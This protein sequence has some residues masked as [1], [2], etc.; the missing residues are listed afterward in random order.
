MAAGDTLTFII[1][2]AST[3]GNLP[4]VQVT[5]TE[6]ADGT[7]RFVL[8][9]LLSAGAYVGDL[10]GFFMDL[11]DGQEGAL[12][13]LS[14]TNQV[15]NPDGAGTGTAT[16]TNTAVVGNDTVV[17]A[18]GNSNNMNGLT[19]GGG[20]DFGIE[21]GSEGIG[22]NGNDVRS[23]AFTLDATANLTLA[24]IANA[25]FGV[26]IMSVGQDINGDGT[27]DTA[28]NGSAKISET[29]FTNVIVVND[30][31]A[32]VDENHSISGNIF[33][34]DTVPNPTLDVLTVTGWSDTNV[35]H[36]TV[37]QSYAIVDDEG[38][39]AGAT[40]GGATVTLNAD[41]SYT[42]DASTADVLSAGEHIEQTFTVN[43][44]Q[45]HY[46]DGAHLNLDGTYTTTETLTV[47]VC[48]VNDGPDAKDDDF[49]A[50]CIEEEGT[51]SGNVLADNGNGADSDVDRL[52]TLSVT[53]IYVGDTLIA[54][55]N[56]GTETVTL[57]SGAKVTINADGSF[58]YDTNGAFVAL[59]EGQEA[60]D[61]FKYQLSDNNGSTDTATATVCI[62]GVGG[63]GDG[64]GGTDEFCFSGLTRGAWGTPDSGAGHWDDV[65]TTSASF[66]AIFGINVANWAQPPGGSDGDIADPTLLEALKFSG[67]GQFQLAA[68]AT[69]ALLNATEGVTGNHELANGYRYTASEIIA[70]VQWVFGLD[71]DIDGD[72]DVDANGAANNVYNATLGGELATELASWNEADGQTAHNGDLNTICIELPDGE[73]PASLFDVLNAASPYWLA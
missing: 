26:R 13:G 21:I 54:L 34:N 17:S 47:E 7:L 1:N 42:I 67:G 10:R 73:T 45:D 11:P 14:A 38:A 25:N 58:S 71:A 59:N 16:Q 8:T 65:Y 66:E 18:G 44:R 64:G 35:D 12:A 28:R 41:G 62:D 51:K 3:G 57:T 20:Y 63:G 23:F 46:T 22:A 48:G 68:Q 43:V 33:C 5:V 61:S 4:R 29:T 27:I 6:N 70:A 50:L 53:G 15:L 56:D 69:A 30:D 49:T 37:G 39:N 9:Q 36:R 19:S 32:C 60:Q 52:D 72:G 24:S 31:P 55:G 2:D 40:A